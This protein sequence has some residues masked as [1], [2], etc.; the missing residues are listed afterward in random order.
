MSYRT[1]PF[2]DPT[3]GASA[4]CIA[5]FPG[6]G[7]TTALL[8]RA[9]VAVSGR[10]VLV[11]T[12]EL[13]EEVVR[14]RLGDIRASVTVVVDA[15]LEEVEALIPSLDVERTGFRGLLLIEGIQNFECAG[16]A[17]E[18]LL[19]ILNTASKHDVEVVFSKQ[20][21]RPPTALDVSP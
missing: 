16:L 7:K 15:S 21:R 17:S 1:T 2:Y 4:T 19:R 9:R 20:V 3:T 14:M 11:C 10:P 6:T 13:S 18:G 12:C 8:D 5:G